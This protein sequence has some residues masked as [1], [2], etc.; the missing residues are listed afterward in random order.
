MI[1]QAMFDLLKPM[2]P[3]ISALRSRNRS[4]EKTQTR[5]IM[6]P[7]PDFFDV[8]DG[9]N[10]SWFVEWIHPRTGCLIDEWGEGEPVPATVIGCC[11]YGKSGDIRYMREP[12]FKGPFDF[13]H[14][15]D[16]KTVAFNL[17]TGEPIRWK[18]KKDVL[19]QLYMPKEAARTFKQYE[20]IQV[21]RLNEISEED[22]QAEGC[23]TFAGRSSKQLFKTLWDLINEQRGYP[24]HE[25]WWVWVIGYQAYEFGGS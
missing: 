8:G 10:S 6:K 23:K 21:Q 18:W 13:A 22:A 11:P 3:F 17:L 5:R 19:S 25:N 1:D 14:Y 16:D 24:W 15:A 20:T 7:Q 2:P 9:I 12:L 4:N